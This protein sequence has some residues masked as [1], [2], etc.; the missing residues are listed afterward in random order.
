MRKTR[1]IAITIGTLTHLSLG[2]ADL[3]PLTYNKNIWQLSPS[4]ISSRFPEFQWHTAKDNEKISSQ[5]NLKFMGLN[6]NSASL[7]GNESN[8]DAIDIT[9]FNAKNQDPVA[10]SQFSHATVSWKQHLDQA[11][12]KV[13][14]RLPIINNEDTSIQRTTWSFDDSVAVLTAIRNP[15]PESLKL[16]LLS[17]SAAV[18]YLKSTNPT[19]KGPNLAGNPILKSFQGNTSILKSGALSKENITGS[20]EYFLLYFSASW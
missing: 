7:R 6:I 9:I 20:P 14:R 4:Q 12:G 10:P 1:T 19:P 8:T 13:G 3:E 11:T 17:R 5:D 15:N 2:A 18:D 16:T